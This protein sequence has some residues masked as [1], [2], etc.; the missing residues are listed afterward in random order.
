M[1]TQF[2][3]SASTAISPVFFLCLVLL[4]L[5]DGCARKPWSEQADDN[6]ALAVRR[7]VD[8]KQI[9][10]DLC[11]S[12][13]D[14]EV[15]VSWKTT[16]ETKSFSGFLQLK[17]PSYVK[18]VTTNPLGQ[19]IAALVSDGESYNSINTINKQFLSGS[20]STLAIQNDI[21]QELLTGRWGSWLSGRLAI[22]PSMEI[23]DMRQDTAA[24]GIWI[25]LA[26]PKNP[27]S[28]KEYIL[29]D[30]TSKR[31]IIRQLMDKEDNLIARIEYNDWQQGKGC[32][33]PTLFHISGL[34]MGSEI[35]L[36]L[37]DIITDKVLTEKDFILKPPPGYFIEL[38][39]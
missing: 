35:T 10:D 39:P 18:F 8:E 28:G 24:R 25:F 17:L 13:L 9:T 12:T 33:Q 27:R 1:P 14:A 11:P 23:A 7:I 32:G 37:A 20:L 34:S 3:K 6:Q 36:R 26:D 31:L 5:G 21:P 16:M 30:P 38:R 2:R 19:T 22:P 29:I 4:F 15:S